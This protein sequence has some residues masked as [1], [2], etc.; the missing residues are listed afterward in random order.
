MI[1]VEQIIKNPVVIGCIFFIFY[2][3]LFLF[4]DVYHASQI[5]QLLTAI[6]S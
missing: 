4:P 1:Y 6:Q 2:D 5:L 3:K